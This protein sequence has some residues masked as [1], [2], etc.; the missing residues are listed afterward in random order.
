VSA[1]YQTGTLRTSRRID[2]ALHRKDAPAVNCAL[3]WIVLITVMVCSL[4]FW[5]LGFNYCDYSYVVK[6]KLPTSAIESPYKIKGISW[7][8]HEIGGLVTDPSP[9]VEGNFPVS[10]LEKSQS[11]QANPGHPE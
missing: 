6:I 2:P 3:W 10:H 5:G 4:C 9:L 8:S 7:D 1:I 11:S